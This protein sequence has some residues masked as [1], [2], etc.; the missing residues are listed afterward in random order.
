MKV[1]KDMREAGKEFL[2]TQPFHPFMF[3]IDF[4]FSCPGLPQ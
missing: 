1:M 3:L 4:M 2:F